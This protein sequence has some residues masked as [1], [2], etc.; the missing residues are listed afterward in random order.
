M[1][2]WRRIYFTCRH[3]DMDVTPPRPIKPCLFAIWT[4]SAQQPNYCREGTRERTDRNNWEDA[5]WH[6]RPCIMCE[7]RQLKQHLDE[8]WHS[9]MRRNFRRLTEPEMTFF[10]ENRDR[11][12][13]ENY[14][15]DWSELHA[16]FIDDVRQDIQTKYGPRR[17]EEEEFQ[18]S[19]S[20]RQKGHRSSHYHHRHQR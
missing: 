13:E 8:N 7:K 11:I 19:S 17:Y 5:I 1:C 6:D 9:F 14:Y 3:E 20:E 15:W 2:W 4:G 10:Q 18:E 16:N 12:F